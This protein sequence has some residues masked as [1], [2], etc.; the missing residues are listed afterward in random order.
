MLNIGLPLHIYIYT[1]AF[2]F[3]SKILIN[4]KSFMKSSSFQFIQ[5]ITFNNDH[6]LTDRGINNVNNNISSRFPCLSLEPIF[7]ILKSCLTFW[8]DSNWRAA[9]L[10][11]DFYFRR[12]KLFWFH[13]VIDNSSG[14]QRIIIQVFHHC[15][16]IDIENSLNL[17]LTITIFMS[18]HT[19]S[20]TLSVKNSIIGLSVWNA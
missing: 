19:M 7:Y 9:Y 16:S 4:I 12:L 18:F 5:H 20:T 15:V 13:V 6:Q 14:N 3:T 1:Q 10:L 11:C 17:R 8:I 2:P